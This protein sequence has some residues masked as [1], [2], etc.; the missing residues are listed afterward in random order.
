MSVTT[1]QQSRPRRVL[2]VEDDDEVALVCRMYLE[3][4][5]YDVR[6]AATVAEAGVLA[7]SWEPDVVSLDFS[8]PDED[9][10]ELVRRLREDPGTAD[11][12]VLMLTARTQEADR[13]DAWSAGIDA[14]VV[15]PFSGDD[16]VAVVGSLVAP[17]DPAGASSPAELHAPP[18]QPARGPHGSALCTGP[19]TESTRAVVVRLDLEGRVQDSNRAAARLIGWD[20]GDAEGMAIDALLGLDSRSAEPLTQAFARARTGAQPPAFDL[21]VRDVRGRTRILQ[22]SLDPQ[23]D[24]TGSPD[25]YLLVAVD[26]SERASTEEQHRG[27]IEAAPDAMVL[28][29]EEGLIVLVN[30][31]TER[32]FGH[33]RSAL[34]GA[35]VEVLVPERFRVAHV[36]HRTGFA[37]AP[38]VRPMGQGRDLRGL[39]ADGHEFPVEISLS[40]VLGPGTVHLAATVRDISERRSSEDLVRGL[41]EAAPDATIGVDEDGTIV[42]A[43]HQAEAL[44]GWSREEL[45]GRPVED[46][47][48]EDVRALHPTHRASYAVAPKARAM[49]QGRALTAQR[50][51]GTRFPAEISLS[52]IDTPS[53]RIVSASIRDV[54]VQR[55][56][57][58]LFRAVVESAPDATVIVDEDGLITLV[59]AQ[60]EAMFGYSRHELVGRPVEV[61]M[62]VRLRTGHPAQRASYA[63]DPGLRPM[64]AG[65]SLLGLRRDGSEFPIEISLSP[66]D[67]GS[68]LLTSASI[69]DVTERKR[70]ERTRAAYE[71][72]RESARR[73]RELDRMRSEFLSTVSHELRTPLTVVKGFAELLDSTWDDSAPEQRR[74][75]AGRIRQSASRLDLLVE[76]LLDLTRLEQGRTTLT[77]V[78]H[79]LADLVRRCLARTSA[80]LDHRPV[81]VEVAEDLVVRADADA[82]VRV[83]ENLL[84]N[85][86]KYSEPGSPIEVRARPEGQAIDLEVVDHGFGIPPEDLER[87]F[88]RFYRVEAT[89]RRRP[90]TGVGLAI[91]KQLV[92]AMGGHV[93]ADSVLGEGSTFAVRLPSGGS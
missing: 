21:L 67:T 19:E 44:F 77:P 22:V 39:H 1:R 40:P 16:L 2:V 76:E 70:L 37:D 49:G 46:L 47:V 88:D 57:D 63:A 31:Q 80:A 64:G 3:Q 72:E 83:L 33:P 18:T 6:R 60:T 51:D 81:T 13:D 86:A 53:G 7:V 68:G 62:P 32:L 54:T 42:L 10:T 58:H 91:V 90:G 27:L 43:N 89:A 78:P 55:R 61:L 23:L 45:V 8:L 56:A 15:K 5:G 41:L 59:N 12:P 82:L 20:P 28:I 79:P 36:A 87:V 93:R 11:L 65:L 29:D 9:G 50:R 25:S 85:A 52:A 24:A 35:P 26:V 14:Y 69:R 38:D 17:R 75:L 92:E 73:L 48:P 84:T 34:I 71:R 30:L 74:E 66:L 4:A